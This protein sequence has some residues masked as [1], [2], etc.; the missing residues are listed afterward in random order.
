MNQWK[1]SE[2]RRLETF[3]FNKTLETFYKSGV[4]GLVRENIQNSL[5]AQL[6][7]SRPVKVI[8]KLSQ[9]HRDSI[10]GHQELINHVRSLKGKNTYTNETISDMVNHS[11]KQVYDVITFEDENTKGLSGS[12]HGQKKSDSPYTAY[13]YQKGAHHIDEDQDKEDLRGGSHGIGKI[14]SNSASYL[15]TMFF[16]NHDDM[17]YKT[18]GGT[19]QLIEHELNGIQYRSTGYF[20]DIEDDYFIPYKNEEFH[21][22]FYKETRGLKIIIPYLRDGYSDLVSMVTTVC[23][24]FL[25]AIKKEKLIVDVNGIEISNQTIENILN[26]EKYF[27][28]EINDKQMFTKLYWET[29]NHLYDSQFAIEDKKEKYFFHLYFVYDEGIEKG[30]TGIFRNIGMKIEDFGVISNKQK[31]YNAVLIPNSLKEDKLLKSLENE[32]HTQL[33][34]KHFKNDE[35][36]ENAKR[37]I[38]NLSKK[39]AEVIQNEMNKHIEESGKL[40]VSDLLYEIQ[41]EAKKKLKE[42]QTE[43]FIGEGSKLAK[44]VKTNSTDEKGTTPSNTRNKGTGGTDVSR[45]KKTFGSESVK[46]Y[47]QI[48]GSAI[49]RYIVRDS[50]YINI[51]FTNENIF[52][53]SNVDLMFSLI[54]GM[55][56]EY[57]D[58]L[59][60]NQKYVEV[61]DIRNNKNVE[62]QKFSIKNVHVQNNKIVLK[63]KLN[64]NVRHTEKIRIYIEA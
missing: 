55:G 32:S 53:H 17:G 11:Y 37:F 49:K 38:N 25:L 24:S 22:I 63:C 41:H 6:D 12:Q 64:P 8:I 34:E 42:K 60:L 21:E 35:L 1:F 16:S 4:E 43:V 23:D 26:D 28:N 13:A 29:F 2:I 15:Y 45:V 57:T 59:N 62:V 10:P 51:I 30:R 40:D 61:V 31:P 7:S 47:Y 14:A 33:S 58:Q 54:D 39:M 56:K 44:V 20:T 50:E 27:S 3:S 19:T 48:Q 18:L 5:D 52:D 36:K 9:L 46:T